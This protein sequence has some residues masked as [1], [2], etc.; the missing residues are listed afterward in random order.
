MTY[1]FGKAGI[2]RKPVEMVDPTV[3]ATASTDNARPEPRQ[4]IRRLVLTAASWSMGG[5]FASQAL[6]IGSNLVLARLLAPELFGLAAVGTMV[7]VIVVLLSDIGLHQAVI[8]NSK[9]DQPEF[10]DTA[11]AIQIIRGMAIWAGCIAIALAISHLAKTGWVP[12]HSIYADPQLPLVIILSSFGVVISGFQSMKLVLSY[13]QLGLHRVTMI[14]LYSQLGGIVVG[15]FLAWTTRSVWACVSF[16]LVSTFIATILSFTWLPGRS[17]RF[18]IH[19]DSALEILRFGRWIMFS[20]FF[21]IISG[22]GDRILLGNW[23]SAPTFGLYTLAFGLVAMLDGLGSRLYGSIGTAILSKIAR[24]NPERL[25]AFYL[26]LRAPFDVVYLS[27]AGMMFACG[28]LVID[29]L[30]DNRYAAA[31]PMLQILSFSL[32]M[33]RFG[34]MTS[35]Y[36]AIGETR[37]IGMLN[38]IK[39]ALLFTLVPLCYWLFGFEGALW[40]IALHALPTMPLIF[41]YNSRRQLNSFMFEILVLL[42]WPAGYGLGY[43]FSQAFT[44]FHHGAGVAM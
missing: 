43:L 24:E 22:N 33:A 20:S 8:Q 6:R 30:Y 32:V 27:S 16:G 4:G 14:D 12:A 40:A 2:N 38:C 39:A 18:R 25:R 15:L 3:A 29:I 34:V 19:R 21:T 42:A 1:Q 9:G 28:H 35:V 5:Y 36:L 31:G 11:W 7:A 37:N 44:H 23:A 17:D 26:K 10:L 41:L 13:R